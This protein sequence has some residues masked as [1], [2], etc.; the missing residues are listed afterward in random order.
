MKYYHL[1]DLPYSEPTTRRV[2]KGMN[3]PNNTHIRN[4]RRKRFFTEDEYD[5][6]VEKLDERAKESSLKKSLAGK[7]SYKDHN[8]RY[9][10]EKDGTKFHNTFKTICRACY[11]K[12]TRERRAEEAKLRPPNPKGRPRKQK[13]KK[14]TVSERLNNYWKGIE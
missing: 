12:R 9:C 13:V 11:N 5:L 8:C 2:L 14:L 7:K 4:G 3:L 6:I 10:H 1:T